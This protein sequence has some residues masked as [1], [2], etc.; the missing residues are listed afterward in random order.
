MTICGTGSALCEFLYSDDHADACIYL[1]Q[2]YIDS[3][4]VNI[5]SG[6]EISIKNLALLVKEAVS[7][8]GELK[9]DTSKLDGTPRK[10]LDCSNHEFYESRVT[11]YAS[12]S[13]MEA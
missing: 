2:N 3:E 4:I 13:W 12:L 10:L 8:K 6:E 5:G 1:M 11:S 9:F 7:Y